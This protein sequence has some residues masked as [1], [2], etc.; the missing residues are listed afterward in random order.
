MLDAP[1]K[2]ELPDRFDVDKSGKGKLFEKTDVK[3]KP[4]NEY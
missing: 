2:Y 4:S 1:G 3:Y